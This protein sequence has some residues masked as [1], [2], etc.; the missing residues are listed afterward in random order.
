M[1][2]PIDNMSQISVNNVITQKMMDEQV[3]LD[4]SKPPL[5]NLSF[6]TKMKWINYLNH[7]N[8]NLQKIKGVL[9]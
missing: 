2:L 9:A 8:P 5:H 4:T 1:E 3:K 7:S 6:E